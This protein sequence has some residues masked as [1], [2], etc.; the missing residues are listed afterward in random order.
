[1]PDSPL[2][3]QDPNHTPPLTSASTT[4]EAPV[5]VAVDAVAPASAVPVQTESVPPV[6]AAEVPAPKLDEPVAQSGPGPS[7]PPSSAIVQ[8][9]D[10]SGT[11]PPANDAGSKKSSK[12]LV[13]GLV[14]LLLVLAGGAYAY[15][16]YTNPATP[17]AATVTT[18]TT[19]AK[20]PT[21]D[22]VAPLQ[23]LDV[24]MGELDSNLKDTDTVLGD[25]QG[26]LSE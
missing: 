26:D 10:S 20:D 4:S 3:H 23:T 11:P 14:V 18:S 6:P 7:A 8:P 21:T 19:V 24:S 2:D 25:S 1:M 15:R 16:V 22:I 12:G 13:I 5:P 17:K 9:F